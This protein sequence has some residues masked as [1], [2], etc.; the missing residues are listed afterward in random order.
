MTDATVAAVHPAAA[1]HAK[2]AVVATAAATAH[3]AAAAAATAAAS[4]HD[5]A[6]KAA[7]AASEELAVIGG[8]SKSAW[9]KTV[10]AV[11]T[12]GPTVAAGTAGAGAALAIAHFLP[13]LL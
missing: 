13:V 11:K 1:A 7:A 5:A 3:T 2:A 8:A 6:A 10:S 4:Q 12:H 9:Q